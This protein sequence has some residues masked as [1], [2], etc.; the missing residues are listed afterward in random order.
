M[1]KQNSEVVDDYY[2]SHSASPEA[3]KPEDDSA[4][5][6]L[7]LKIKAKTPTQEVVAEEP[8]VIPVSG[9]Q[10]VERPK[11]KI[12]FRPVAPKREE[13]KIKPMPR[14]VIFG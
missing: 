2:S 3:K 12:V 8:K 13:E 9:A 11:P 14:S 4:K 10:L 7:K 6:G 5:K 1:S